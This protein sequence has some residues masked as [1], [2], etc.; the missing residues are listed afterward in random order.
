MLGKRKAAASHLGLRSGKKLK[1]TATM[2]TRGKSPRGSPSRTP[3]KDNQKGSKRKAVT[4]RTVRSKRSRKESSDGTLEEAGETMSDTT[5]TD[6]D[7]TSNRHESDEGTTI[8][9]TDGD[10][11]VNPQEVD[12]SLIA[13]ADNIKSQLSFLTS[14][15]RTEATAA[16]LESEQNFE[17]KESVEQMLDTLDLKKYYPQK[18]KYEDVIMLTS[19]IYD[20]VNKKPTSL[21]ELPWYFMKHVIGMDSDARENSYVTEEDDERAKK[22]QPRKK[23]SL[24][25]TDLPW[26]FMKNIIGFDTRGKG[27]EEQQD[28][29]IH[30]LDLMYV[31]FLCA[32]DFLRQELVEKMSL[33]QYAIPFMLP[34]PDR[35]FED[36][37]STVLHWALKGITRA[38]YRDHKIETSTMV[39]LKVPLVSCVSFG[40]EIGWKSKL[41]NRMLSPQQDTFWQQELKGGNF[42]QTISEGM[43]E[44]AWYL[45]GRHGNNKFPYPVA[46]TNMRGD[47][48]RSEVVM[49]LMYDWSTSFCVFVN[50]VNNELIEFLDNTR[51]LDKLLLVVLYNEQ[52]ERRVMEQVKGLNR[53]YRLENTQV[54]CKSASDTNFNLVYEQLKRSISNVIAMSHASCSITDIAQEAKALAE[55][56]TDNR[57]GSIGRTAASKILKDTDTCNRQEPRSAKKE[58]LRLQS[59]LETRKQIAYYEKELCRQKR[60]KEN[61]TIQKYAYD[62]KE[63]KWQL[64][65]KQLQ[66]SISET[67][68]HFLNC[69]PR[70]KKVDRKY[71]LQCLKLGLNERSVKLLQPLYE[72]YERHRL[73]NESD[74]R[75]KQ[76]KELDE[77]LTHSSLGIEHFFREMA[78]LYENIAALKQ[79]IGQDPKIEDILDVLVDTMAEAMLNGTAVEIV[80]GDAVN[81]PVKWL[82]A[83]FNR[84]DGASNSTL[85]RVSVLGALSSGKSTLLNTTFGMNFPVSSGRCTR[86]AYMQL[87]KVDESLQEKLKCDCW[88]D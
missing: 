57:N 87:V 31:I 36:Q 14:T 88:S 34:T 45:P 79:K 70:L 48:P 74:E 73:E 29:N 22:S 66:V 37:K 20:D 86:G 63:K 83:V 43:V 13:I 47:A 38:F 15:T 27:D 11:Q 23:Q 33:C 35:E 4:T 54:L 68:K 49:N 62:M 17:V 6:E 8:E 85:F 28:K 18:L 65:L 50:N 7:N 55:F 10:D 53:K 3:G 41:L 76:L 60:L 46:F 69:L 12:P 51:T 71:F 21:Q 19:S 24:G 58:F 2:I 25:L 9:T 64:Q 82:K 75:E 40:K 77:K 39:D 81:V 1:T 26:Y 44:L 5:A 16:E 67:I 72:E 30:P 61:T 52:E 78:I 84:I 42:E 59:D 80:D 32:D 56:T